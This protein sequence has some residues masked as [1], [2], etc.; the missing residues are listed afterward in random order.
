MFAPPPNRLEDTTS[1]NHISTLPISRTSHG[2]MSY[3]GPGVQAVHLEDAGRC[4]DSDLEQVSL[5]I[6][7]PIVSLTVHRGK[8]RIRLSG[9]VIT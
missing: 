2:I 7:Q 5:N 6:C 9:E 8:G 1:S 4:S 3:P